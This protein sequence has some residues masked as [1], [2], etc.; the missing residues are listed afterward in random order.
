M[1]GESSKRCVCMNILKQLIVSLYSP[2]DIATF[3]KQG[4]GKTI[5]F[6]FFLTLISVLPSFYYFNTSIINGLNAIENTVQKDFPA[7]K[8]ENGQLES[9]EAAPI[10]INKDHFTIVFDSTGTIKQADA[11]QSNN[12]IFFLKN[13]LVYSASG[14]VQSIPYSM[15]GNTT[16]TQQD[17]LDFFGTMDSVL[18]IMIPVTDVIIYI[19]SAAMKF[20]EV[21][22][23]ALFGLLFKNMVGNNKISYRYLWRLSA[24]SVTLPTIFFTI[25]ES[26]QTIVP[27]GFVIHWFVAIMMLIL[28]L[29]EIHS[30]KE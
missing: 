5:L 7:F 10:T 4:I 1:I 15:L 17:L 20:I 27:A 28:S 21:S 14:Q 22:V 2:K 26:L 3:H 24:Y 9:E 6:V 19:I 16:L 13:E 11:I 29:K 18:P 30:Q 12:S 8:I 23:L 25:M